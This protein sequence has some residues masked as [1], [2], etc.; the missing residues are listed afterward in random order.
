MPIVTR[1]ESPSAGPPVS[2][3]GCWKSNNARGLFT[4]TVRAIQ[5]PP[6]WHFYRMHPRPANIR[7]MQ[8]W[9]HLCLPQH[10]HLPQYKHPS[11]YYPSTTNKQRVQVSL[12]NME[13]KVKWKIQLSIKMSSF[14]KNLENLKREP[15]LKAWFLIRNTN[16]RTSLI[17]ARPCTLFPFLFLLENYHRAHLTFKSTSV[18]RAC[19]FLH[20]LLIQLVVTTVCSLWRITEW[21]RNTCVSA[22]TNKN[23]QNS[24]KPNLSPTVWGWRTTLVTK[25]TCRWAVSIC[26]RDTL[27]SKFSSSCYTITCSS[28][29]QPVYRPCWACVKILAWEKPGHLGLKNRHS[30]NLE[31]YQRMCSKEYSSRTLLKVHLLLL[32][33]IIWYYVCHTTL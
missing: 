25:S 16:P 11:V 6:C 17:N 33:I 9:W 29:G 20:S 3:D 14:F 32:F 7:L 27:P 24:T 12:G 26:S 2:R 31:Q 30:S 4:S 5:K 22:K 15:S 19:I 18:L 28:E 23:Q 13:T 1:S 21:Y 8:M 10:V